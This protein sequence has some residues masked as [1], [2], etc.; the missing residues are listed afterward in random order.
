MS[1]SRI[2]GKR[3]RLLGQIQ[4]VGDVVLNMGLGDL[5]LEVGGGSLRGST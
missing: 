2:R 3:E 4:A 5:R 1:L